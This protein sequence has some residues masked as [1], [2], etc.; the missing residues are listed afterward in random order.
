MELA[1]HYNTLWVPEYAREYF[2]NSDIYKYTLS[3][4]QVIAD[5][6]L[7][8]ERT[9]LKKTN[10]ILFC[11]TALQTLKIWAELE[12]GACPDSIEKQI[13]NNPYDYFLI[14]NNEVEWQPDPLRLNKFSRELI[15]EL[16]L[17]E[18]EK[19]GSPFA[20]VTGEGVERT[21]SAIRQLLK[22]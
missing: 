6:Q 19:S 8:L 4:L 2:N 9:A 11:D 3:D 13:Q 10:N 17:K 12:F 14:T 5:K 16:N 20:I 15:F 22:K 7:E 18:A 1:S 21:R